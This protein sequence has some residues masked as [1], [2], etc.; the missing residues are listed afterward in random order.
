[1]KPFTRSFTRSALCA[2][3]MVAALIAAG[4]SSTSARA[5][6]KTTAE[7]IAGQ[8]PGR[9]PGDNPPPRSMLLQ[10][11]PVPSPGHPPPE[12]RNDAVGP[13]FAEALVVARAALAACVAKG[14]NVGVAVIDS[15]G[16]P[17]VALVADGAL[18]GHVYTAVRKGLAAL[19]F[20]EPTSRVSEQLAAGK[21]RAAD[22]TA[23]M[24]P[25]A[26]AVPLRR[27]GSIIGAIGVS[28]AASSQDEACAQAGAAA[29]GRSAVK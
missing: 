14:R 26:G 9:L 4:A 10:P 29:F 19:A 5:D 2:G 6:S 20:K 8:T 25:W 3:V 7:P 24:M 21:I 18:G 12:M 1:M 22:L 27:R 17:R 15:S 23:D 16:Q 11:P 28:G 13:S